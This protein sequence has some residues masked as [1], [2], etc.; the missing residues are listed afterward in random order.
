MTDTAQKLQAALNGLH[1]EVLRFVNS[2]ANAQEDMAKLTAE[3]ERL[4]A[5]LSIEQT[6]TEELRAQIERLESQLMASAM[7]NAE[8]DTYI[9]QIGNLIAA[10]QMSVRQQERTI[11]DESAETTHS[12]Q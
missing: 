8:Q 9:V 7:R 4:K 12:V 10:Y 2:T 11:A 5:E 6:R 3:N 1:P